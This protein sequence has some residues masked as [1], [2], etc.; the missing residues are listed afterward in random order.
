MSARD[1]VLGAVRR[2]VGRGPAS[3]DRLAAVETRLREHAVNIVP[4]RSDGDHATRVAL[5]RQWATAMQATVDEAAA[6]DVPA[7]VA[8]YPAANNLPSKA[9]MAPDPALDRYDWG[10]RQLLELRRGVPV[11]ADRVSITGALAGVAET[12][13]LVFASGPE[14][15]TSLNLLPETHVVVLR[16]ADIVGPYE[17]VFT[18]LR[19]RYGEGRMPR[20]VNTVTGPSR[21]GDIEQQLELGA[22]GP[23]RLHI[24]VARG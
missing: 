10:E 24:V 20:T 23:R 22:H 11:D 21:T 14:H 16:E 4:A 5:F 13:T 2:A 7:A 9:V 1:T 15:P 8:D 12:G 17:E 18:R 3:P 19:A 6:A